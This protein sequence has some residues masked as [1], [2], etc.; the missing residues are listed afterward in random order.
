MIASDLQISF[1]AETTLEQ[2]HR[3]YGLPLPMTDTPLARHTLDDQLSRSSS[4]AGIRI[5]DL[6]IQPGSDPEH[7]TV[8]CVADRS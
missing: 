3:F 7:V 6:L 2:L 8:C 1:N 4:N 5:G